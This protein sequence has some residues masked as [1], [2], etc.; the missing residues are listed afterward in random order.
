MHRGRFFITTS[1]HYVNAQPHIGHAYEMLAADILSRYWRKRGAEVFFLT[2]TDEHG[3]KVQ[4]AA[5]KE[6]IAPKEFADRISAQYKTAWAFLNIKY[7]NFIRTTDP[8]HEKFVQGFVQKLHDL[9]EIYKDKY[10][11]IYCI[12]C[13]EYK[14]AEDLE[15]GQICPIHKK[16]C[17]KVSEN[18]YFFKLSKYQDQLME[19]IQSKKLIIEPEARRNE[20]FQFLS[21]EPLQDLA[22]SR[23]KVDW[24][25][26]V[27]WDKTQTIYVWVDALLNYLSGSRGIWPASL[28][29]IGKD[30]F[31]FHAIIWPAMLLAGG[32]ELPEKIFIH[33]FL[34]VNGQKMSKT[35]GNVIDPTELAKV[36]GV[37]ALRYFLFREVPFGSDGDFSIDRF[38]KRYKADLANDLGNLLQRVIVV[39]NNH[40]IKWDYLVPDQ[41]YYEIDLAMEELRF[42]DALSLIW[43]IITEA[44]KAIDMEKPWEKGKDPEK[45]KK[46]LS[47]LLH[48]LALISGLLEPFMPETSKKMIDQLET[49][50]AEPLFPRKN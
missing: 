27:P 36:Y 9:G 14:I 45:T 33:G 41:K 35:V 7:D 20:I 50:K 2:G 25:V 21:K 37:D 1:I 11:G 4:Q 6:N 24:G 40:Q 17:E 47:G 34:T 49:G 5:M 10:E 3:L 15:P 31:R 29:L 26:P 22:I 32:Y 48:T 44:N 18:I 23:S 38:E 8:S 46:F 43:A 39:A 30:I 19:A 16:K 12:G 13:E 28:Q 42:S